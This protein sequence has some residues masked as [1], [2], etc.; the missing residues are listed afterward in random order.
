MQ[1]I[2]WK[3]PK[4]LD[5][6]HV[7]GKDVLVEQVHE[8]VQSENPNLNFALSYYYVDLNSRASLFS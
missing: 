3:T 4:V 5:D 2:V 1:I 7:A 8:H 6:V